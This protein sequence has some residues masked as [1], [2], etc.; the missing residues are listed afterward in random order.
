MLYKLESLRGIAAC[1]VILFHSPFTA[2][3]KNLSFISNSYLF[4]DFFFVLSGFVIA[5]AYSSRISEGLTFKSYIIL[6]LGRVYPLHVIVLFVWV[7]YILFKQHLFESGF[8]GTDQFE[9]NNLFSFISNLLLINS[10]GV[11]NYVSWNIPAWS[12]S[13]EFFAYIVFYFLTTSIDKQNSIAFPI[14]VSALCYGVIAS[15]GRESFDIT[16]DYGFFRC[17]GAFYL[18]VFVCRVNEKIKT[19]NNPIKNVSIME[20]LCLVCSAV[21]V[22]CANLNPLFIAAAIATFA[23]SI[24]VFSRTES[25]FFG[26]ALLTPF[27]RKVGA[28]SYSIYMLQQLIVNIFLNLFNY[29]FHWKIHEALGYRSIAVNI[30]IVLTTVFFAK[31]SFKFIEVPFRNKSRLLAEK[32]NDPV[33][34]ANKSATDG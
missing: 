11:N 14:A 29:I 15:L 17:L 10:M 30:A 16:Y 26:R 21:F 18:G 32:Y 2:G 3:E 28:W 25:G 33:Y 1:L 22:T 27:F 34:L 4:V 6:R 13:T 19:F 8:G 5:L 23:F 9:K 20:A 31:L 24:H 7:P 12:I